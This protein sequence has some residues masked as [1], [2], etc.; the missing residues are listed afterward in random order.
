MVGIVHPVYAPYG[1]MVGI[2]HPVYAPPWYHG[3]YTSLPVYVPPCTTPGIP[4]YTRYTYRST[5]SSRPGVTLREEEVLG[6]RVE[7]PL[8]MRR[9]EPPF[10]LSCCSWYASAQRVTPSP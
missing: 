5:G 8:G 4:P 9:M 3:G 7:K 1:T 2:V 10:P 6:S